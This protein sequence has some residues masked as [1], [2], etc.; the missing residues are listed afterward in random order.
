MSDDV[1]VLSI[2]LNGLLALDV[3]FSS[4]LPSEPF[5]ASVSYLVLNEGSFSGCLC[6]VSDS[7][8]AACRV[9]IRCN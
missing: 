1:L 2:N 7:N 8:W 6:R 3:L 4:K 9:K 5:R